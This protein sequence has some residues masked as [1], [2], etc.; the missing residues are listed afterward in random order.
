MYA[1]R[2]PTPPPA[3][4]RPR[5]RLFALRSQRYSGTDAKNSVT[6]SV[7]LVKAAIGRAGGRSHIRK[8]AVGHGARV[9]GAVYVEI[10]RL[11]GRVVDARRLAPREV[12]IV[13]GH[14]VVARQASVTRVVCVR[15]SERERRTPRTC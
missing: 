15:P 11:A 12:H 14:V 4:S 2:P 1:Y 5:P 6:N 10:D 8:I 13:D 3:P 9:A 7:D